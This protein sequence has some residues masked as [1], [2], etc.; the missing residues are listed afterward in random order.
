MGRAEGMKDAM[1]DQ[2]G[3]YESSSELYSDAMDENDADSRVCSAMCDKY[4][5]LF[6]N[7]LLNNH[8]LKVPQWEP[9]WPSSKQRPQNMEPNMVASAASPMA[10]QIQKLA[11][12]IL[13]SR[14]PAKIP[15]ENRLTRYSSKWS[16][17]LT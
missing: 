15:H 2:G 5:F 14:A 8:R 4:S 7:K 6:L 17:L 16:T 1:Q 9:S 10:I 3:S 13:S 11:F 12:Q